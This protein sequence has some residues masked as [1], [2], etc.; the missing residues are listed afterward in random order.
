MKKS[1]AQTA[2]IAFANNKGGVGKTTT[3]AA[4]GTLLAREGY[5]TLL[6]DLDAQCSLTE[7]FIQTGS[8]NENILTLMSSTLGTLPDVIVPGDSFETPEPN[9]YLIPS[10]PQAGE[11]ESILAAKTGG[12]MLL[13]RIFKRLSLERDFDAILID[14][15]PS[16]GLLT[17]NALLAANGLVVPTTAE[18][19]PLM[20]IQKLQAKCAELA[21]YFDP[22]IGIDGILVTHY[23]SSK[24]LHAAVDEALRTHYREMVFETKIRE[25]V[26]LAECPQQRKCIFDYAPESNGALDYKS[27]YEEFKKRF[28]K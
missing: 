11:L 24:N 19:M 10:C 5:K 1:K 8:V 26:R 2:I 15:P 6:I 7:C 23:N 14:C 4:I 28:L 3:T 9:L 18:Y 16:L 12:E 20:G 22:S 25:N 13:S 27:F 17:Q 21:D